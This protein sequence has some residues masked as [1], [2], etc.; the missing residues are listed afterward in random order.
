[1][2]SRALAVVRNGLQAEASELVKPACTKQ[3]LAAACLN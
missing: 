2:Q 3:S 1:M